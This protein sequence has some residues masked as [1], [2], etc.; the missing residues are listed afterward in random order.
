MAQ[1]AAAPEAAAI[2]LGPPLAITN[3]AAE[4]EEP[5]APRAVRAPYLVELA[6]AAL[7]QGAHPYAAVAE[8]VQLPSD[9]E[10]QKPRWA[11]NHSNVGGDWVCQSWAS[12]LTCRVTRTLPIRTRPEKPCGVDWGKNSARGERG[13]ALRVQLGIDHAAFGFPECLRLAP[14]RDFSREFFAG[15]STASATSLAARERNCHCLGAV[16]SSGPWL[17]CLSLS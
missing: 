9:A 5:D 14:H 15:K 12:P 10:A 8:E 4:E 17:I 13:T 16:L 3:G 2:R 7:T 1:A 6:E 11:P